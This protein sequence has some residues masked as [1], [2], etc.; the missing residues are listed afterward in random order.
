M[1][2]TKKIIIERPFWKTSIEKEDGEIEKYLIH[3]NTEEMTATIESNISPNPVEVEF[4]IIENGSIISKDDSGDLLLSAFPRE[5]SKKYPLA[6]E[7]SDAVEKET[8]TAF[9][10]EIDEPGFFEDFDKPA[11]KCK[12]SEDKVF[13]D[14]GDT[15]PQQQY[16]IAGSV[17]YTGSDGLECGTEA[18]DRCISDDTLEEYKLEEYKVADGGDGKV[19]PRIYWA[20]CDCKDAK[21]VSEITDTDLDAVD[22]AFLGLKEAIEDNM[23]NIQNADPTPEDI[24]DVI[25]EFGPL[26]I[27]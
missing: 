1:I 19:H 9:F 7:L 21:C 3:F 16:F 10:S 27:D 20:K 5:D 12:A 2:E 23:D 6:V 4:E 17:W 13:D 25:S 8:A 22:G 24:E 26:L 14:D 11:D 18:K 15:G